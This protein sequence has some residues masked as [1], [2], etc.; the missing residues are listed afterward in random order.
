MFSRCAVPRMYAV[1]RALKPG[2]A[3]AFRTLERGDQSS[4]S[5]ISSKQRER[6]NDLIQSLLHHA[7]IPIYM[8]IHT[9]YTRGRQAC[10]R[11]EPREVRPPQREKN[12]GVE[13]AAHS[14]KCI[15]LGGRQHIAPDTSK[16]KERLGNRADTWS[17]IKTECTFTTVALYFPEKKTFR[18]TRERGLRIWIGNESNEANVAASNT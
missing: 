14:T 11:H 15:F 7:N 17:T 13:C 1:E 4:S 6:R 12:H 8:C 3:A 18:R 16:E 9:S 10:V 5:V 2:E